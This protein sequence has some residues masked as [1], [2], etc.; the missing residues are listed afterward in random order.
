MSNVTMLLPPRPSSASEAANAFTGGSPD[1]AAGCGI[2]RRRRVL[3][4]L[5]PLRTITAGAKRRRRRRR[6]FRLRAGAGAAFGGSASP[7]DSERSPAASTSIN[8]ENEKC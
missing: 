6:R 8:S 4:S 7:L 2:G 3:R 1:V 5:L